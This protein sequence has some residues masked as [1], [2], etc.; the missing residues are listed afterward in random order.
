M[1]PAPGGP[2]AAQQG[3]TNEID[4]GADARPIRVKDAYCDRRSVL[5]G[6][7]R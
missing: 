6:L 7:H 2:I 5:H 3:G 1:E 4:A